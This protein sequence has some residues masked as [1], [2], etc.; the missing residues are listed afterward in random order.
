MVATRGQDR[1]SAERA[2]NTALHDAFRSTYKDLTPKQ[3]EISRHNR[4]LNRA[5]KVP[6]PNRKEH[7]KCVACL[8]DL[9]DD[10][11]PGYIGVMACDHLIHLK[12]LIRHA[13]A[14]LDIKGVPSMDNLE[15]C[16]DMPE[17]V[18]EFAI[19]ER[20]AY[21]QLGAPCPACRMEFPMQHMTVFDS[22]SRA[23]G[24]SVHVQQ[25]PRD[26]MRQHS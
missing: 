19:S 26:W 15:E 2:K 5:W 22:G 20:S 8:G 3:Q 4:F 1:K 13:D 16:L 7:R 21:R 12:C 10:D 18:F 6:R 24:A 14:H 25:T 17:E 11:G 23:K 9:L